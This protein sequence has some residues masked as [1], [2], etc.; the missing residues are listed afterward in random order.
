MNVP[1][2]VAGALGI[3]AA[4]IHGAGG[5]ALV[6]RRLTPQMLPPSPF[7][8]PATTKSMIRVTWHMT[9]VAFLASGFALCLSGS[10]LHGD[11]ARGVAVFAAIGSTG[12]ATV[13]V[14][15]V[16]DP[17]AL[18]RHPAPVGLTAVAVLAWWGAR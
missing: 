9:T 8:G 1:L 11:A 17:R 18:L 13:A 4:A 15:S 14:G 7:G 16:R 6:L 12:F 3:L 10:V 2:I 5:E